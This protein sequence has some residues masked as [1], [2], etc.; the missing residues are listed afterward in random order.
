MVRLK[1]GI[2]FT[3][4]A[5]FLVM[6]VVVLSLLV[7]KTLQQSNERLGESGSLDRL[8]LLKVS[9]DNIISK[10]DNGLTMDIS[11]D[12]N[13]NS[14]NLKIAETLD[15]DFTNYGSSFYSRM[16]SLSSYIQNDQQEI[17]F[18]L[19]KV[20]NS[21]EKI[22]IIA[23]PN[24]FR[25]THINQNDRVILAV[26]PGTYLSRVGLNITQTSAS[27][28]TVQ[29]L[30]QNPGSDFIFNLTLIGTNGNATTTNYALNSTSINR[31]LINNQINLTIGSLCTQCIELD[32]NNATISTSLVATFPYS[33]EMITVNY[34]RGLYLI[35]FSDLNVL[36]NNT[37]R[38]L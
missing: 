19:S 17:S 31:F 33:G 7:V 18:D 21:T 20:Y 13:T 8:Y 30:T 1:K 3:F 11:W 2:F 6:L 27:N 9:I 29:W 38:I 32:R 4:S 28:P 24:N 26:Y 22:P 12:T 23:E 10:L 14:T 25:Y 37:P 36:I 5:F 16:Q 34:P 15:T 35:N